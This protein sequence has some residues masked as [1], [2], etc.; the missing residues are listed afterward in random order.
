M[1][2]QERVLVYCAN[3]SQGHAI[4]DALLDAGMP[5]RALVRDE[6]KAA[7][8]EAAGAELCRADLDD[9]S[10]LRAAHSNVDVAVVQLPSGLPPDLTKAQAQHALHAIRAAGV[11]KIVLNS[12]VHFPSR[13]DELPQF[14]ARR[15]VEQQMRESGLEVSVIQAPCL[16]SNLLLPW[17]STPVATE[18]MLAYPV[19]ADIPLCW[20]AP[21]D[22]GRLAALVVR[23]DLYGDR[24]DAGTRHAIRGD[25]LA[26]VFSEALHRDVH[27]APLALDVFEAGVDAAIAPGVGK[28]IG[29]IFRFI[30]RHP[31]DRAFVSSP[32]SVPSDFPSFEPTTV[33]QWIDAHVD[34]FSPF[35]AG[36]VRGQ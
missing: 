22:I 19:A 28:D 35:P 15:A 11:T 16:L 14:A 33:R 12:S 34:A 27:Y 13:S 26:S 17:A 5:V 8:L 1:T 36:P 29:A 2:D 7:T 24:L 23:E 25:E 6:T 18:G 9:E 21:E 4:V 3:G 20:A 10:S 31:D 32:F 30:D